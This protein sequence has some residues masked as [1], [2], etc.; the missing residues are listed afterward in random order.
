MPLNPDY[1]LSSVVKQLTGSNSTGK[2]SYGTEGE[3]YQDAD[4]RTVICGP[5]HIAQA[6]QPDEFVAQSELDACDTFIRRLVDR[7]LL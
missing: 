2:V 4:I 7:L 3:F 5:R 1:E 6:R